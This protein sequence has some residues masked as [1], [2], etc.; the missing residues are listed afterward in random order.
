MVVLKKNQANPK[1]SRAVA[2]LKLGIARLDELMKT[3]N[4]PQILRARHELYKAK[5]E[6]S[7]I[8]GQFLDENN[9]AMKAVGLMAMV[10]AEKLY[11]DCSKDVRLFFEVID[12]KQEA[13]S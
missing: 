3:Q 10:R 9:S 6:F 5:E 4:I 2:K 13:R 1:L 11:T 8:S 12:G 7:G